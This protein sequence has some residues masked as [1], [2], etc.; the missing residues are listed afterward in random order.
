MRAE[1][2]IAI[3]GGVILV[4]AAAMFMTLA[5]D[6]AA[7]NPTDLREVV[8]AA[9]PAP[10]MTRV[11][12][13]TRDGVDLTSGSTAWID[14]RDIESRPPVTLRRVRVWYSPQRTQAVCEIEHGR[15]VTVTA[16]ERSGGRQ[17]ALVK[18]GDCQGWL[19]SDL[20][21][22]STRQPR[23]GNWHE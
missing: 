19:T 12:V 3:V 13:S 15:Q 22:S 5:E 16:L 10:R 11:T 20:F 23:A 6:Y 8:A 4:V 18:L 14:G 17:N 2:S 9:P 1:G 21:L 7:R